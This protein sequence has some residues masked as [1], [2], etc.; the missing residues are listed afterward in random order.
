MR[1]VLL[2]VLA[3]AVAAPL[4][5]NE[6]MWM[7]HQLG[8][9]DQAK[10]RAMG[11]ELTPQQLWD[12]KTNSGLASAVVSLGGC[13]ASFVSP[14]GLIA[15]NHHCAFGAI[16]INSTPEHD[17]ITN[18]FLAATKAEELE[19]KG[20]RVTVF[21]GYDNI[22]EKVKS[23]LKPAMKPEQRTRAL[24]LRE[25]E[26]VAACEKQGLRCRFAEMYGGLE[27]YM[28]RAVELRDVRLVYAPPR[29]IGEYGGEVD[30]W[31]WPRHTGDFSFLRA[32]VGK[33]GKPADFAPENVPYKPA[34]WLK[35]S[36]AP[37]DEGDFTMILGYP[38]RTYRYRIAAAVAED[39]DFY[40]PNRIALY[41]D[42]IDILERESK[43][44]KDVEI[45]LSSQL[46]GLYNGYKNN[47]GMVEGL[48]RSDLAGRKRSAEAALSTWIAADPKR[49]AA[50]GDVL[51]RMEA[52]VAGKQA[53]R[54][55]DLLLTQMSSTRSTSLLAAALTVE[56]WTAERVKPD[57]ERDQEYQ[58]RDERAIRSRL[59][60]IQRNLD[61]PSDRAVL[62]YLFGRATALPANQRIAA[63]DTALAATGKTGDAAVD[64][65]L[66]R[67][68]EGTTLASLH[69]RMAMLGM[70]HD[71]VL[72]TGDSMITFAA[73]L[74]ADI[75]AKEDAS[76][77]YDGDMVLLE[78]RMIEA[79]AAW[80]SAPLYPDANSTL[81]FTYATVKGYVPRD[82][83]IYTPFTT[84]RGVVEKHT[85][86]EPFD[87]PDAL[88]AAART[89]PFPAY[90]DP[91]V[92]DVVACFLSTNDIT[93]GNSGSP[94]LN[95]RGELIGLAF[96]GN[97]EAM[98]SD[99]QFTDA[100]SRTINVDSR[101]M[102]WVM[103]YVSKAHNLLREM[104]FEPQAK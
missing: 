98:T 53:T 30:N 29:S 63:I 59:E 87:A 50:Y 80:K 91:K 3:L 44:G 47:Q 55:R 40:Y 85:G 26:L 46:K 1:R 14:E 70:S 20:T 21:L 74:R 4:A 51:P 34:R 16:Q 97:Y 37:L 9:L 88:L 25:N 45:K 49:A 19:A 15:T 23:A 81:R 32:Y 27:Y 39:T 5:A 101:Y 100:M 24:E 83:A 62:R 69:A 10:L 54:D 61:Q 99:Y 96:D 2:V 52:L 68:F 89:G 82:G 8:Q 95:G 102:L 43:R 41:K 56:H 48:R 78:P 67:L 33:D 60:R 36:T 104:G 73:A 86:E 72:A 75:K 79:L 64:V 90:A 65:L 18:G 42:L 94:I 17:Y 35:V 12:I 103:D 6:G 76:K 77:R 13:S 7:L 57:M 38:G 92:G 66:D 22:T 31:E 71:A 11:L 93:G 58:D 28:F 84:L